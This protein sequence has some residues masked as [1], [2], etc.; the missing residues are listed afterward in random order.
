MQLQQPAQPHRGSQTATDSH[1]KNGAQEPNQGARQQ[2]QQPQP[3]QQQQRTR[4]T[5][6]QLVERVL[7]RG[8]PLIDIGVNLVDRSFQKVAV[9]AGC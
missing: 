3:P 7:V 2:Q 5:Q 4:P 9:T 6:G 8:P 1:A